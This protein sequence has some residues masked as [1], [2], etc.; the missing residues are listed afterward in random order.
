MAD[1]SDEFNDPA[2]AASYVASMTAELS[3]IARQHRFDALS[4]ILDMAR[5][6]AENANRHLNGSE[7]TGEGKRFTATD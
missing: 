7:W 6:E 3:V 1:R 5:L 4:Y 2:A